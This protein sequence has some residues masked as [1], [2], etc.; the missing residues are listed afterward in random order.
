MLV[1]HRCF[2]E[3]FDRALRTGYSVIGLQQ[4]V[5][6]CLPYHSD[7]ADVLMIELLSDDCP[8]GSGLQPLFPHCAERKVDAV[9][10]TVRTS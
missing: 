7:T 6:T 9:P 8:V 3:T 10:I 1:A 5:I 4:V 2:S